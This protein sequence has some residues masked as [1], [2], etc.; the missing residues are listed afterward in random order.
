MHEIVI[1]FPC[2][3]QNTQLIAT[4]LALIFVRGMY[5]TRC[6]SAMDEQRVRLHYYVCA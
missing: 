3:V 2:D 6:V 1:S 4:L 5:G